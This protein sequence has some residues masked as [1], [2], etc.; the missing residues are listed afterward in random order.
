MF[1][2]FCSSDQ[3]YSPKLFASLSRSIQFWK[4][5][6]ELLPLPRQMEAAKVSIVTVST[7]ERLPSAAV[8]TS[9]AT[10]LLALATQELSLAA[11][12]VVLARHRLHPVLSQPHQ[13]E[14]AQMP[15][16]T[17]C[18][19]ERL[20]SAAMTTSLMARSSA[21]ATLAALATIANSSDDGSPITMEDVS[22][23]TRT[24]IVTDQ[25]SARRPSE[26]QSPSLQ[27]EKAE[28]FYVTERT[29]HP[30]DIRP[31]LPLSPTASQ[32]VALHQMV[33]H[34]FHRK[35]RADIRPGQPLSPTRSQHVVL[36][37]TTLLMSTASVRPKQQPSPARSQKVIVQA[38]L[39]TT[40]LLPRETQ[41]LRRRAAVFHGF[42]VQKPLIKPQPGV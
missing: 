16:V 26:D 17:A 31:E 6:R 10:R 14:A 15:V 37:L 20:P 38:A 41:S 21:L 35:R 22:P 13:T 5:F 11:A 2:S 1:F 34:L 33:V 18:I 4:P 19:A 42:K 9:P 40:T 12:A 32:P 23:R 29:S 30:R 36:P 28:G 27:K 3:Y 24:P 8:R 25:K 39:Q 7:T